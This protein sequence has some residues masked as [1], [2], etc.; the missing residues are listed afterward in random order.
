MA[1]RSAGLRELN[2]T[3]NSA[4]SAQ[5][6][7]ELTQKIQEDIKQDRSRVPHKTF[8]PSSFECPRLSWFRLRGIAPDKSAKVDPAVDWTAK[9]GTAAHEYI[10][11]KLSQMLG[12]CW[13][14]IG[15]YFKRANLGYKYSLVQEGYETKVELEE[16]PIRFAVD[17]LM[18]YNNEYYLIEIKSSDSASFAKLT[19][20]KKQHIAQVKCYGTILHVKKVLFIYVDR[21]FGNMKIFEQDITPSDMDAV[22][23][24]IAY[25]Q[26]C[27][28]DNLAPDKV[29]HGSKCC[30]YCVYPTKCKQWG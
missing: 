5:L 3:F 12:G 9:M 27:V 29:P 19:G 28:A 30:E 14:D 21:A 15:D 26:Q 20:P 4:T 23:T 16:P 10:Q 8:A 18:F 2:T 7:A 6:L 25:V 1:F 13:V 22:N 11:Q 24:K 17:G